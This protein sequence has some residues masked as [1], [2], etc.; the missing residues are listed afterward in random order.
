VGALLAVA[1]LYLLSVRA[2]FSVNPGD[3]LVFASSFFWAAHVLLIGWWVLRVGAI[4]LAALQFAVCAGLSLIIAVLFE[5]TTLEAVR[6]AAIPIIYGGIGSVG[7]AFTLQVVAQRSATPVATAILLS[8]EAV[9]AALGGWW[10]LGETLTV[11]GMLGCA[12]ML[13]G[14]LTSQLVGGTDPAD[15]RGQDSDNLNRK[16]R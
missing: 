3:V 4:E 14:V 5:T 13:A 9:F 2:G 1:G 16:I 11:R 7:I 8:L 12:L 10:L 6:A 15:G